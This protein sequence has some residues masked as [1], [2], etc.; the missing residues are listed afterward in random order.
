MSGALARDETD[1]ANSTFL[2]FGDDGKRLVKED[3]VG[4]T[5]RSPEGDNGW[6]W[7]AWTNEHLG[8]SSETNLGACVVACNGGAWEYRPCH[9][10]IVNAQ[11]FSADDHPIHSFE[12]SGKWGVTSPYLRKVGK[13][14]EDAGS[15]VDTEQLRIAG[16]FEF[17]AESLA[18]VSD[19]NGEI[20]IQSGLIE[21]ETPDLKEWT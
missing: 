5:L 13:S 9:L 3:E 1:D 10:K 15:K 20:E 4:A 21:H 2:G 17:F 18:L 16:G 8:N 12:T 14:T 6:D 7:I 11:T 19:G